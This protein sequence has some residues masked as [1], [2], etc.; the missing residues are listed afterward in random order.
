MSSP[1][2][3]DV[4]NEAFEMLVDDDLE[5]FIT[6]TFADGEIEM[7]WSEARA[8]ADVDL[9]SPLH[10]QE[11]LGHAI[12]SFA[13]ASDGLPVDVAVGAIKTARRNGGVDIEF[14]ADGGGET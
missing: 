10:T 4:L 6:L 2:E 3:D 1:S 14:T 8:D 9:D 11:M 12:L 7:V 5:S 13:K